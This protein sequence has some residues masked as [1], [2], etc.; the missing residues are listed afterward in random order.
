MSQETNGDSSVHVP[1][2][3][4]VLLV[5]DFL[6]PLDVLAVELFLDRDMAHGRGC[7]RAVPVL[8]A[9]WKPDDIAGPDFLDRAALALR[10]AAARGD[11]SGSDRG[12]ACTR[13]FSH[14]ART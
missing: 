10:P 9:G 5:A 13:R 7:R 8:L 1:R 12:D 3:S 2:S 14:R 6:H 4:A 11:K